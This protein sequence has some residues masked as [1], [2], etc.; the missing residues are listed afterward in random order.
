M[1]FDNCAC[2]DA[3]AGLDHISCGLWR[4]CGLSQAW[5]SQHKPFPCA[6]GC[7]QG[8]WGEA[9]GLGGPAALSQCPSVLALSPGGHQVGPALNGVL[10]WVRCCE[11]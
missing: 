7:P 5:W 9:A 3:S 10:G 6:A 1:Q 4:A 11:T 2:L 8:C